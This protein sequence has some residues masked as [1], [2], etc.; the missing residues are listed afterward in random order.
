M[1]S[2]RPGEL[3]VKA[4]PSD[5]FCHT[6][7]AWQ[8]GKLLEGAEV[9]RNCQ[10]HVYWEK[11]VYVRVHTQN[12]DNISFQHAEPV[13]TVCQSLNFIRCCLCLASLNFL[14]FPSRLSCLHL[15]AFVYL[16]WPPPVSLKLPLLS[17]FTHNFTFPV[18]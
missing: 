16:S 10:V 13:V 14:A 12:I 5:A 4:L 7:L 18:T 9:E 6:L 17:F 15:G 1:D 8:H 2:P 11:H 3:I